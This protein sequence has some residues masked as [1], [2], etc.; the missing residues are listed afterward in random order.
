MISKK[1]FLK[2]FKPLLKMALDEDLGKGDVT[3][4]SLNLNKRQAKALVV[5]KE[6]IVVCGMPLISEI[7][8]KKTK[9]KLFKQDSDTAYKGETLAALTGFADEILSR[10]RIMLNFI[11]RLSGIATQARE[12]VQAL[13]GSGIR[14]LDTRKTL[15]GWRV[16]DKYAVGVGGGTNHRMG[17]HDQY[18]IKDNHIAALGSI[19]SC[20][21]AIRKIKTDALKIEVECKTLAEVQESIDLRVDIIMLDNMPFSRMEK[22]VQMIPA[23]THI[24][25]SGNMT[26]KKLTR[27]KKL[28]RITSVSAGVLTHSVPAK[29][30]SLNIKDKI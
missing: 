30:I 24:E 29:D 2:H 1:E 12:F 20:V 7:F 17:L 9:V 21:Q 27:I 6:K 10:E 18:M 19:T 15:P 4:A 23:S 13:Q 3:T 16:L 11:Q 5:A 25:I 8:T 26:L 22:A 28:S 14:L